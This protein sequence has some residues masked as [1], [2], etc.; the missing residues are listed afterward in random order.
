MPLSR[1]LEGGGDR[2]GNRKEVKEGHNIG[3]E[4]GTVRYM[5]LNMEIL[6]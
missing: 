3:T 5:H 2:E 6:P 1:L 4:K